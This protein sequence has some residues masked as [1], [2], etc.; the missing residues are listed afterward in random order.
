[1]FALRFR[2]PGMLDSTGMKPAEAAIVVVLVVKTV[3]VVVV[4]VVVIVFS[5]FISVCTSV[6][7]VVNV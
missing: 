4:V 2:E 7:V 1:M 3:D 6:D 5:V